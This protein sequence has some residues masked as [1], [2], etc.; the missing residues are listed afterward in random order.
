MNGANEYKRYK[1]VGKHFIT[2]TTKENWISKIR[3]VNTYD[4]TP[5]LRLT[6]KEATHIFNRLVK[7]KVFVLQKQKEDTDER[8]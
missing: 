1:Y 2:I 4:D 8:S 7:E 5:M 6:K 3:N